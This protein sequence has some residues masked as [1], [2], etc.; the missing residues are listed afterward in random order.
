MVFFFFAAAAAELV[1]EDD[2][3]FARN[4][5]MTQDVRCF[6]FYIRIDTAESVYRRSTAFTGLHI[7]TILPRRY[8]KFR[9]RTGRESEMKLA[10][11]KKK[12]ISLR[13]KK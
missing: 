6:G 3:L 12:R 9:A 10:R 5:R 4:E 11:R 8:G 2:E 7:T 13:K 1:E